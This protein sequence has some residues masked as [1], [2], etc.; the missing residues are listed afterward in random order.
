[1]GVEL[2]VVDDVMQTVAQELTD[3]LR[4]GGPIVLTGGSTVSAYGAAAAADPAGWTGAQLWFTD[5]RCVPVDDSRSNYGSVQSSLLVGLQNAGIE[6]GYCERMLGEEG[7]QPGADA[8]VR[9]L[10]ERGITGDGGLGFELLILGLGPDAHIASMFPGQAS[11]DEDSSLVTGV[12]EAGHEPF[13]PRITLTFPAL[14]LARHVLVVAAGSGKA[15]AVSAAFAE[16]APVSREVP[17]SLLSEWCENVLVLVDDESA[18]R[19]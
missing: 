4:R 16:D 10:A 2:R 17:A 11:L 8:Y 6:I 9:S 14:A 12:P 19:L 1:M 7:P 18:A 13:V 5:E 15:D 3:A